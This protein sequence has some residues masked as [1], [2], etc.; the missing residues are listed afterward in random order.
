V[1]ILL[2]SMYQHEPKAF[3]KPL[4]CSFW[5]WSKLEPY[6]KIQIPIFDLVACL[7]RGR[8]PAL[9]SITL[10]HAATERIIAWVPDRRVSRSAL[11]I[12]LTSAIAERTAPSRSLW[13]ISRQSNPSVPFRL[14]PL[15]SPSQ[16]VC[17]FVSVFQRSYVVAQ[18]S[19]YSSVGRASIPLINISI[20]L[21]WGQ[22]QQRWSNI[23]W[24]SSI[25]II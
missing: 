17:F 19:M 21:S 10:T 4:L 2:L 12:S 14:D 8:A 3:R 5:R 25:R 1:G 18:R 15:S 16:E 13:R 9:V 23:L 11:T 20:S 24:V 22:L 6:L 7:M